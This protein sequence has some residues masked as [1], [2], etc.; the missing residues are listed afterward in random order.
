MENCQFKKGIFVQRSCHQ[1]SNET[2]GSCGIT[3][4]R[5]H[6]S[7][8]EGNLYCQNC[9]LDREKVSSSDAQ[10]R[11]MQDESAYYLWYASSRRHY[12]HDNS[13]DHARDGISSFDASDYRSFDTSAHEEGQE[14]A[15]DSEDDF[16]DS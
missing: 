14:W 5:Y 6:S 16:F 8:H 13:H 1:L 2:C 11:Y 4:C 7:T 9:Y 12:Y 10:E 3:V 15:N